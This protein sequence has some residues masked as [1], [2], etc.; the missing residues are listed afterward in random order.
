MAAADV[1]GRRV[2]PHGGP[3]LLGPITWDLSTNANALAA[4]VC[5]WEALRHATRHRYPEPSYAALRARLGEGA[6]VTADRVLPTAGSSEAIRRLTLAASL[7]GVRQVR[8]PEPGFGEYRAAAQALGLDVRPWSPDAP[9]PMD[10]GDAPA[11]IWVCDPCNPTGRGASAALLG[12]LSA[13]LARQPASWLA[14]DAAYE[15]LRLDGPRA[16]W[17]A[18]LLARAWQLWSPNK[19]LGLTGVRAGW[20]IAPAQAGW[21]AQI[22]RV[23]ALAPSWVL[24]A[25]GVELLLQWHTPDVTQWLAD[26]RQALWQWRA[27]QQAWWRERGCVV[28]DSDTPFYLV[29]PPPSWSEDRV[30][31]AWPCWRAMGIKLRNAHDLGLPGWWRVRTLPPHAMPALARAWDEVSK[32][33]R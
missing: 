25:E 2:I 26:S 17:P 1:G 15:P 8:V 4:P 24:S 30:A 32:E 29:A 27:V 5:V 12:G 3:D 22:D 20:M 11:L 16:P 14:W 21:R 7:A 6:G 19:A 23:M 10:W 18:C 31:R 13:H 28:R 33:H 9:Q